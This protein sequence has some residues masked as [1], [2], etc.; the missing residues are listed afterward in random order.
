MKSL[1]YMTVHI[2]HKE[3]VCIPNLEGPPLG[4]GRQ[5]SQSMGR[6]GCRYRYTA[7][8]A[9]CPTLKLPTEISMGTFRATVCRHLRQTCVC[10]SPDTQEIPRRDATATGIP[11]PYV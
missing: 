4:F 10:D 5:A 6:N 1:W 7:E 11:Y 3:A 9:R 8:H 2:G